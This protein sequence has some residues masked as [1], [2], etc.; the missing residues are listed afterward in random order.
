MVVIGGHINGLGLLRALEARG[1]RTAVVTTASYDLAHRS[2]AVSGWDTAANLEATPG[3]LL[4]TLERR[5]RDWAGW[6]LLPSND[7]ALLAIE[8]GREWLTARHPLLA[9]DAGIIPRVL[10]KAVMREV[11]ARAGVSLPRHFGMATTENSL[12][13]QVTFPAVVKPLQSQPFGQLFGCKLFVVHDR[14]A[15]DLAVRRVQQAAVPC[16]IDAWIGGDDRIVAGAVYF[17]RDGSVSPAVFARKLRQG[18]PFAGVARVAELAPEAVLPEREAQQL[19]EGMAEMLRPLG[20]HGVADAE[21]KRDERTGA[22]QFIE[23]NCRSVLYNSLLLRGGF[24]IAGLSWTELTT[25]RVPPV[26]ATRWPG[27]WVN[28]HADL[29][30]SVAYRQQDPMPLARFLAPYRR[31]VLDAVWSA[32]DPLP[33]L[34]QWSH[35]AGRAVRSLMTPRHVTF[36]ASSGSFP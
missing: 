4:E 23:V 13:D 6:A 24:D 9:P 14:A 25:G 12:L 7:G 31:P 21:F 2:R 17:G 11:A 33:G 36:A 5:A 35:T 10:D 16:T 3:R 27:V 32:R 19:R 30:Y 8:H 29:L 26:T 1:V 15:L 18:P 22:W 34:V 20:F 28:T